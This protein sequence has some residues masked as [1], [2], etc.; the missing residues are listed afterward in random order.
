MPRAAQSQLEES[1]VGPG[2]ELRIEIRLVAAD[3]HQQPGTISRASQF[4]VEL[5][6]GAVEG[7]LV[8]T[9]FDD[10]LSP[11]LKR[12]G[13]PLFIAVI[14]DVPAGVVAVSTEELRLVRLGHTFREECV[15]DRV[16]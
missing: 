9:S 10:A 5:Q 6:S 3:V 7:Q 13:D 1:A 2:H 8:A 12:R 11:I 14:H 16:E 4:A 15:Y